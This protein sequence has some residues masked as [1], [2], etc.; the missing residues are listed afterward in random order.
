VGVLVGVSVGVLVGVPVGV[1]V[2]ELVDVPVGVGVAIVNVNFVQDP[3]S[4]GVDVG[5]PVSAWGSLD[6]AVGATGTLR[7]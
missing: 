5:E 4:H 7:S 2:G 1:A 6:G 3:Y